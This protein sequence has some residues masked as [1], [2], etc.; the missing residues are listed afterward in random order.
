LAWAT[1]RR[2]RRHGV[3]ARRFLR[4]YLGTFANAVRLPSVARLHSTRA[5]CRAKI[6]QGSRHG[7]L[8][9]ACTEKHFLRLHYS[10]PP[11]PAVRTRFTHAAHATA[12]P[13]RLML[14]NIVQAT[15]INGGGIA[16]DIDI[17]AWTSRERWWSGDMNVYVCEY[18]LWTPYIV[19]FGS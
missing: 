1:A 3:A 8:K 11:V 7:A 10:A 18:H 9:R 16:V 4:A 6:K 17:T 5:C 19:M 15:L 14:R 13:L 12:V 2:G